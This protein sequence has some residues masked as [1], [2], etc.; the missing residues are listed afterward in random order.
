MKR[1]SPLPASLR[2]ATSLPCGHFGSYT[3]YTCPSLRELRDLPHPCHT[4]SLRRAL[5]RFA[6]ASR[7]EVFPARVSKS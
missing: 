4:R 7:G 2:S 3:P 5:A 1:D 6:D